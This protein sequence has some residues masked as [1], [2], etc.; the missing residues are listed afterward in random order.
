MKY[1]FILLILATP[2]FTQT[3]ADLN[4]QA[5]KAYQAKDYKSFLQNEQRALQLDPSNPRYLYD[6][7]CGQS[8]TGNA[9]EAVRLLDQLLARKLDLGAENDGDF[10][11]IHDTPEWL[12]F[13]SRLADLRKPLVHSQVAFTLPRGIVGCI[14]S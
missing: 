9:K 13:Q 8:L 5:I 10:T 2:A 4:A 11:A 1:A 3:A 7:A 12:G 6:V 14:N